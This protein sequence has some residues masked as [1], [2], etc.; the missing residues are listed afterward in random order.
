MKFKFVES[1]GR[2]YALVPTATLER[3]IGA[4]DDLAD[5][6]AYDRAKAKPTEFVPIEI[7][8]RVLAGENE[9]KIWREYRGLTQAALAKSCRISKPY[10][11]QLEAGKRAPS[12]EVLKKLAVALRVDVDDLI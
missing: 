2:R 3:L 8:D 7:A 9:I 1:K 5:I 10:L 6:Q 4:A 12:V 11:S